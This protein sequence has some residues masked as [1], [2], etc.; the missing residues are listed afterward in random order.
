[1]KR[2]VF[3]E[4]TIETS[5]NF[6]KAKNQLGKSLLNTGYTSCSVM[7]GDSFSYTVVDYEVINN[8]KRGKNEKESIKI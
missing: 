2:K 5:G 3:L 7:K 1:M 4:V 6:D 8:S